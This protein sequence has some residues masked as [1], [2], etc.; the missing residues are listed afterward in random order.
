MIEDAGPRAEVVGDLQAGEA[1]VGHDL[2]ELFDEEVLV[3]GA[4]AQAFEDIEAPIAEA[5][6]LAHLRVVAEPLVVPA[7]AEIDA[8]DAEVGRHAGRH[9]G[10]HQGPQ[11]MGGPVL[12]TTVLVARAAVVRAVVRR[13][14][15]VLGQAVVQV[16]DVGMEEEHRHPARRE[17]DAREPGRDALVRGVAVE[18][19]HRHPDMDLRTH[20]CLPPAASSARFTGVH[21]AVRGPSRGPTG[22][23]ERT[24]AATA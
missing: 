3:E 20:Q 22:A 1:V 18:T 13:Q 14:G 23:R 10:L 11:V 24:G 12:P 8:H 16:H 2:A 4:I 19:D 7:V 6:G 5:R 17:P 15:A 9:E 21:G